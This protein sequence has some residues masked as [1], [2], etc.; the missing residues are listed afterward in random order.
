[1][2]P[3]AVSRD[4]SGQATTSSV[5]PDHQAIALVCAADDG[6][7]M[8]LAVTLRSVVENFKSGQKLV[9]FIIDGGI[10]KSNKQKVLKSIDPEKICIEWITPSHTLVQNLKVSGHITIVSYYRL[11]IP[12]LLP[13]WV[14]KVIYLDCDLVVNA[15]LAQLW[16]NDVTAHHLLA[17]QDMGNPYVSSPGGLLNYKELGIPADHKYFNA[18]VMVINVQKW[19]AENTGRQVIEYIEQNEDSVL[20]WDQGGLNAVLASHW[21]ELDLRWN[22]QPQIYGSANALRAEL[23]E[24]AVRELVEQPFIVHYATYQ[25]PWKYGAKNSRKELFFEYV[26]KTAWAEWRP[27]QSFKETLLKSSLGTLRNYPLFVQAWKAVEKLG[28]SLQKK[29]ANIS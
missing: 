1:M 10:K 19:R 22:Q 13:D 9:A 29:L 20:W 18:G 16:A 7:V 24:Q 5:S 23:D 15:D 17:V 26:D 2:K 14:Q 6:Y 8:Q 3:S 11:L 21:G 12:D 4:S 28:Y 27:K 25:K